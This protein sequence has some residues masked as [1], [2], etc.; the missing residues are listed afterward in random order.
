MPCFLAQEAMNKDEKFIILGGGGA[1]YQ[2]AEQIRDRNKIAKITIISDEAKL[3]YVR[4]ML[5]K[6]L[7]ADDSDEQMLIS[8]KSWYEENRIEVLLETKAIAI[9]VEHKKV[10]LLTKDN[11]EIK[12]DYD[13]LIYA[14]G[15]SAFVPPIKGADRPHVVTIRNI[16]DTQKIRNILKEA[17][18]AVVIGG[19]VLGLEAACQLVK[20]NLNITVIENNERLLS[21]QLDVESSERLAKVL[22]SRGIN[23]VTNGGVAQITDDRVDLVDGESLSA[24]LVI[25]STGVRPNLEVA[26]TAGL[27]IDR[28]IVVDSYMR[29]NIPDIYA[30]GDCAGYRGIN[31]SLWSEATA[32][33]KIAGANAG[34]EE[35]E[36]KLEG[37]PLLFIEPG[38][39]LYVVG[40]TRTEPS[41]DKHLVEFID[42][43]KGIVEKL[44]FDKDILVGA[45]VFGDLSKGKSWS[46]K[47]KEKMT[48]Q[49]LG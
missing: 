44:F 17:T 49:Q 2:A 22:G 39:S 13:K 24:D 9:D 19:G 10:E 18:D 43:E 40:D 7:L 11:R 3:P 45:I 41:E 42:E 14:L 31:Y 36:Y 47:I 26:K 8:P 20:A 34:G 29:T 48:I 27:E 23:F 6:R 33:G 4:T 46:E 37:Y 16:N 35:S 1:G 15:A 12:R 21:R 30:C 38:L 32:M 28:S 5:T 25:I